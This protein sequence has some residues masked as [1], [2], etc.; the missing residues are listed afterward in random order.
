MGSFEKLLVLTVIFLSAVVLAVSLTAPEKEGQF[1]GGGSIAQ[2][3][4][5]GTAAP[6][7][8]DVPENTPSPRSPSEALAQAERSS[9]VADGNRIQD[10]SGN[11]VEDVAKNSVNVFDLEP[12]SSVQ[13]P[14]RGG[15][16]TEDRSTEDLGALNAEAQPT[17]YPLLRGKRT[18]P[19]GEPRILRDVPGLER[20]PI[21]AQRTYLVG[22]GDSWFS[23]SELFYGSGEYV[24]LLRI[25]NDA[26]GERPD[27]ERIAVPV[28]GLP[29]ED[30]VAQ[31]RSARDVRTVQREEP[32]GHSPVPISKQETASERESTADPAQPALPTNHVVQPGESLST[33]A[34]FYYGKGTLWREIWEA[35][36]DV[37]SNPDFVPEGTEIFI[38]A[39]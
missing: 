14:F 9:Q 16:S 39:R 29:D 28:F 25:A 26:V 31:P 34:A 2:L 35:N 19:D 23:L 27:S 21:D 5:P 7:G 30:V 38:P 33:I 6:T 24:D 8:P 13:S 15:R 4:D 17:N 37:I 11:P 12:D 1:G 32:L 20:S 36:L 18:S 22:A 10:S 3:E